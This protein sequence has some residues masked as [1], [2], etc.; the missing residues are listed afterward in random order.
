MLR[1]AFCAMMMMVVVMTMMAVFG[2][3][4]SRTRS[5]ISLVLST[6]QIIKNVDNCGDISLGLSILILQCWVKRTCKIQ[7]VIDNQSFKKF[8]LFIIVVETLTWECTRID[9]LAMVVHGLYDG[10]TSTVSLS[11]VSATGS[12]GTS[13]RT[14][15]TGTG[16]ISC[17]G[18]L[19]LFLFL[20]YLTGGWVGGSGAAGVACSGLLGFWPGCKNFWG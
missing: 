18:F 12:T 16:T 2:S 8:S 7:N 1:F 14:T 5:S 4:T 17:G 3:W 10:S 13:S 19:F 15:A 20:W 9:T 6:E 11:A